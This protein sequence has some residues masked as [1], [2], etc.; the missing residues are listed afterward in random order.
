MQQHLFKEECICWPDMS[1]NKTGIGAKNEPANQA[2][3]RFTGGAQNTP[4]YNN[5][6]WCYSGM[7]M[8]P[9][10]HIPERNGFVR[11]RQNQSTGIKNLTNRAH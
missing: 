1:N 9:Q 10:N 7:T 5:S 2:F 6:A 3:Q 4:K 8:I 11:S